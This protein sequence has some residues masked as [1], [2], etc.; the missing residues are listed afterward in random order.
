MKF[1]YWTGGLVLIVLILCVVFIGTGAYD[2]AADEPHWKVTQSVMEKVRS[3]SVERRSAHIEVPPLGD[4][5]LITSGAGNYDAMCA[6]CH[7]KPS[8]DATEMSR[9]LHPAPPNFTTRLPADDAAAF[10]VIKHG[11]KMSGMPAWGQSMEDEYIWGLVAFLKELPDMSADRY[12][13]LVEASGGHQ[14]GGSESGMEAEE[15]D[16]GHDDSPVEDDHSKAPPHQ[17]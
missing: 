6:G 11:I 10:W 14:H 4:A 12:R 13:E 16:H 5:I 8:V 17:H 1:L 15:S 7:L 9:G 3:A 2:V